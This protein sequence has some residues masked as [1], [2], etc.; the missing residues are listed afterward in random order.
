MRLRQ[1]IA[2][3]YGEK[4]KLQSVY[5]GV[6]LYTLLLLSLNLYARARLDAKKN[7]PFD[8]KTAYDNIELFTRT[9]ELVRHNYVDQSKTDYQELMHNALRGMLNS[10]DRHSQF[11]VPDVYED[12]KDETQ[13]HFGGLGVVISI[14]DDILTVVSPMEDSPAF[15]AGIMANDKIVEIDGLSTKGMSIQDAVKHLKGEVDTKVHL[16][17]I[18]AERKLVDVDVVR[19]VISL[20]SVK[21]TRILGDGIGYVR[22]TKFAE[23]TARN[24]EKALNELCVANMRALILDLRDNPGG[25]LRSA[26]DVGD[27]FLQ[28]KALIVYTQGRE[29]ESKNSRYSKRNPRLSPDIPV[30]VLVNAGSASAAEI[31]AGALQD[32]KRAVLI[33]VK[34][35]GKGSVQ[36]IFPVKDGSALRLTTAKYYTPSERV[37]HEHGIEPDIEV[38]ISPVDWMRIRTRQAS[39]DVSGL[40]D[41][42]VDE[43]LNEAVHVLEGVMFYQKES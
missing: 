32:H 37:I 38:P 27:L 30:V 13:G 42:I 28:K 14:R 5:K 36:T 24:L 23:P 12:M 40:D 15:H 22:L 8:P 41:D 20:R 3:K 11:M 1:A 10:L 17:I 16:K 2:F 43:Q 26:V 6:F 25:L 19:A 21:G 35:F 34:T 33:G 4:M 29:K 7:T 39:A 31:V 18:R 9:V